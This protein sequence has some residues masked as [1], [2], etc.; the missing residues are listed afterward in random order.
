MAAE[1]VNCSGA[2][3]DFPGMRGSLRNEVFLPGPYRNRFAVDNQCVATLYNEQV[4]V[5]LM[6]M[7]FRARSF[8]ACPKRHLAA[9]CAFKNIT[10]NSRSRLISQCNLVGRVFHEFGEFIHA[11]IIVVL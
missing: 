1:K 10:F 11:A 5:K 3:Q 4:F 6:N 7:S 9:V 2:S 8:T